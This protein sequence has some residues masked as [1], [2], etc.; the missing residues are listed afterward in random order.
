[1][2][3]LASFMGAGAMI[4]VMAVPAFAGTD[5]RGN[6]ATVFNSVFTKAD[7]GDNSIHGKIV[8]SGTIK[9]GAASADTLIY[10]K[11]NS[12]ETFRFGCCSA[13]DVERNMGLVTSRT[14][15]VADS[16]DNSIGG[17]I[18]RGGSITTGVVGAGTLIDNVLNSFITPDISVN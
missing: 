2:K 10:N 5:I 12:V 4:L 9:T 15:T 18:V 1:M 6:I 3:K 13:P 7:S 14:A 11:V 16:G 17:K 8:V